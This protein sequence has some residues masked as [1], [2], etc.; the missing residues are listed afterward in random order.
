MKCEDIKE[1]YGQHIE[2]IVSIQ[3]AENRE[4]MFFMYEDGSISDIIKGESTHI[5][6]SKDKQRM[7]FSRGNVT[8]TVHTHPAG[9]DPSTVDIMT[10]VSTNQDHMC[11]AVPITYKDGTK[12]YTL[13]C[14]NLV[15]SGRLDQRRLFRGMRRSMFSFTNTGR[16]IRKQANLQASNVK[17]CRT[18]TVVREGMSI[19]VFDRPSFVDIEPGDELGVVDGPDLWLACGHI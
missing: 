16:N 8:G 17:G 15:E 14:V 12:D 7:I 6:I 2:E 9:F 19:P 10:A 1:Q 5:R 4:A 13:S 18:H 3:R 11:V